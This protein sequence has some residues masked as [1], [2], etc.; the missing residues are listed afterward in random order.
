MTDVIAG[1]LWLKRLS[2]TLIG[3]VATLSIALAGTGTY[4]VKS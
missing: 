1:S 2:A 3:L 4:S